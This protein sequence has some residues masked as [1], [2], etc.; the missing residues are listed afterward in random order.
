MTV[1]RKSLRSRIA[2]LFLTLSLLPL[3]LVAVLAGAVIANQLNAF[4]ER[5]EKTDLVLHRDVVGRNL[6]IDAFDTAAEIDSF[7]SRWKSDLRNWSE[8][9]VI[10]EAAQAEDLSAQA[11]GWDSLT[12]AQLKSHLGMKFSIPIPVR[13]FH[14][15]SS[16]IFRQAERH[17]SDVV[18]ILVTGLNGKNALLTRPTSSLDHQS[19]AWWKTAAQGHNLGV[20]P[21]FLEPVSGLPVV[22]L[23]LPV[24]N[25]TS[26]NTV[27][28]IFAKF[29][30]TPLLRTL[31]Q[32]ANSLKADIQVLDTQGQIIFRSLDGSSQLFPGKVASWSQASSVEFQAVHT[33]PGFSGAGFSQQGKLLTGYARTAALGWGVLVSQP[34]QQAMQVLSGL[35]KTAT[36][37]RNLPWYLVLLTGIVLIFVV[38]LAVF[39]AIVLSRGITRPLIELSREA[40]KVQAGDLSGHVA[41]LSQDEVGLL[42]Q[43][44]NTMTAGL[45]ERER[46]RDV[47]GRVVSPA[48]RERLLNGQLALGGETRRVTVLFTDIRN[49]STMVETMPPQEAVGFLNEYLT[50]MTEA[51][52]PWGGFINNFIGDAIVVIFGA[53]LDQPEHA[54]NAVAAAIAMRERLAWLNRDRLKQGR[55]E[56]HSGIGITTGEVVA[57]Q[58]GSMERIQY[59]VI[60]DTVNVAA[61]LETLTKEIP[62]NPI[63][64]NKS[65]ADGAQSLGVPLKLLG[66][67]LVKGRKEPVEVWAVETL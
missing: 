33:M 29:N 6:R 16:Y 47:F 24:V 36:D 14:E 17:Q 41:I 56:I 64:M 39:A 54:K 11:R 32:K 53:P 18:E 58:I 8:E 19:Q 52:R 34:E 49:F 7:F 10:A 1:F 38:I 31:A 46:E 51:I 66:P 21:A 60:G 13:L 63:L 67:R 48:V 30:L 44:F 15:A 22:G 59:T 65:T 43:A 12:E 26:G 45:R 9:D 3:L 28:V 20:E 62:G 5:L 40:Q 4:S 27:G 61:R 50:Q 2:F 37:F 57:G 55:L 25:T 23:S 42:G 35:M